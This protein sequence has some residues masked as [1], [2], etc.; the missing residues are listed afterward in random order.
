MVRQ[1]RNIYKRF[2]VWLI[3]FDPA[4]GAETKK[5]RPAVI[6]S[7]TEM[8]KKLATVIVAPLTSTIRNYPSRVLSDF[9]NQ[10]GQVM[11][12]QIKSV[13]KKR[14]VRKLGIIDDEE[15]FAIS[16]VLE[17]MFAY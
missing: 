2:E 11:L 14:L 4:V 15:A 9:G 8:N 1:N 6:V 5:M 3:S 16:Q 7:D 13:D 10:K 12:D 17:T